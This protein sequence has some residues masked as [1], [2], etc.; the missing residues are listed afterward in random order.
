VL[1][2]DLENNRIRIARGPYTGWG[3]N[4]PW[5]PWNANFYTV[6]TIAGDGTSAYLNG[7]GDVARFT[8]PSAVAMGPG[9]IFY[10][11]ERSTGHR[12]R[13]LRWTGG[14]PMSN[15][16]WQVGLLAGAA[17]GTSGYL[18]S[19][20]GGSAL[21]NDPRGIAVGPDGMIYVADTYNDCIRKITPD[22]A[23]TTL[24][25]TNTDGY[26]DA[27][28]GA[29]RFDAPWDVACGPDGYLYVADR[30][31][32]RIRRV[33]PAGVVTTVSGTGSVTR[34]DGRGNQTGHADDLG[35]A[36]SPSGDVYIAE[37]E[38]VRTIERIIDIG[39]SR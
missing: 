9:G 30:Y 35:V 8:A 14:D 11:L 28:G 13:T 2:T 21:F 15:Q 25:G 7:R 24:A 31:N 16:N 26:V 36:I 19:A 20:Y 10:V 32:T 34:T 4:F 5:E 27:T 22:G 38:C 23:V 29:A 18:N 17:D 3:T 39:D 6:S 37:A 12:V 1:I 33:S